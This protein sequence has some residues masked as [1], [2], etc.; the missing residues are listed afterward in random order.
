MVESF[1][2]K[3]PPPGDNTGVGRQPTRLHHQGCQVLALQHL[4]F[5]VFHFLH[6][7]LGPQQDGL[8]ALDPIPWRDHQK[9]GRVGQDEVHHGE[10]QPQPG[11]K[12]L[13]G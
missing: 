7:H 12:P 2:E 11:G 3:A 8:R 6:G 13:P 10:D 4:I 5:Q 1:P 9:L